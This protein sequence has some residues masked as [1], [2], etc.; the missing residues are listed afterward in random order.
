MVCVWEG[1]GVCHRLAAWKY[2]DKSPGQV[3]TWRASKSGA[4]RQGQKYHSWPLGLGWTQNP[5]LRPMPGKV[6]VVQD[7]AR[8]AESGWGHSSA[9]PAH[10]RRADTCLLHAG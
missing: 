10:T 7:P 3:G 6:R 2:P 8:R 1:A 9:A 5:G 4:Q